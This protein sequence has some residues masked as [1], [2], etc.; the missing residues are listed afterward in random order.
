VSAFYK[1]DDSFLTFMGRL[2]VRKSAY[3]SIIEPVTSL[4]Q[5]WLVQLPIRTSVG[6]TLPNIVYFQ[7]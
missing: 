3:H 6:D 7:P 1:K 2:W 5:F 4:P